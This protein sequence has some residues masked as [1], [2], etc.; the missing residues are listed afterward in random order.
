MRWPDRPLAWAQLSH[1]KV[2][3]TV[4]MGGIAFANVLIFM[5]LGFLSMFNEGATTL[6]EKLTGD[7]FL[8][9][10]DAKS[11][12]SKGFARIRLYQAGAIDGVKDVIPVYMRYTSWAY[13]KDQFTEI[14]RIIAYD[15]RHR[16]LNIPEIDAQREKLSMPF[17]F[18]FDRLSRGPIEPIA[19][20]LETQSMVSSFA[21][22]RRVTAVGLFPMGN[23]MILGGEGNM[24]TRES[25]YGELFGDDAL[26]TVMIGVLQLKPGADIKAVQLGIKQTVPGIQ[27]LTHQELIAKE[28]AFQSSNPTGVIFGFGAA[29][30]FVVGIVIVYQILYADVSDH[31]A[32]YA[33]LK[34]MGYSDRAL[35]LVIFQESTFLAAFGYLPGFG[36]SFWMY[37]MLAGLTKLPL[38]M[39]PNVAIA[40]FCLTF[41]MCTCSAIIASGKLR[42]ADPADVF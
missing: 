4:A 36:I 34:A 33:T 38:I 20:K 26:N 23:S 10:A 15:P 16:V 41:A 25:T 5:Q 9:D 27:V 1:Q 24:V 17:S 39:L 19:R 7:L 21:N 42:S 18:L 40:V 13:S 37:Q 12:D 32:E 31:L 35:L 11:V 22:N 2:R 3:L 8:M 30:G 29:M 6:P 14:A 28:L